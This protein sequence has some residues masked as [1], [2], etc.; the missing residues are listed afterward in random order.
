VKSGSQGVSLARKP[1]TE[2]GSAIARAIAHTCGEKWNMPSPCRFRAG[3]WPLAGRRLEVWVEKMESG[4]RLCGQDVLAEAVVL[5][6]KIHFFAPND[7]KKEGA[8]TGIKLLDAFAN[9]A[10]SAIE[11]SHRGELFVRAGNTKSKPALNLKTALPIASIAK[12]DISVR[13]E[14]K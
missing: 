13:A 10:A 4:K 2:F 11:E 12:L 7:P 8:A 9:K 14:F 1:H 3:R 6:G 5:G